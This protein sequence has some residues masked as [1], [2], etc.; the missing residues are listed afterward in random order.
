MMLH[1]S[2][3]PVGTQAPGLFVLDTTD[4]PRPVSSQVAFLRELSSNFKKE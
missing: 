2:R 3:V 4:L 1:N